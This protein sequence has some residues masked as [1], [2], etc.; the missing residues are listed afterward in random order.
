M[1]RKNEFDEI[2]QKLENNDVLDNS[3]GEEDE[4]G[5]ILSEVNKK[6]NCDSEDNYDEIGD[7]LSEVNK[8]RNCDSEDNS[9]DEIGDILSEVNKK[10]K[11]DSEENTVAKKS[12][13]NKEDEEEYMNKLID[14][15]AK[16]KKPKQKRRKNKRADKKAL[17]QK[18]A[19]TMANNM[20]IDEN[21]APIVSKIPKS[22]ESEENYFKF[23]PYIQV[24]EYIVKENSKSDKIAE[25]KETIRTR[26]DLTN[27]FNTLCDKPIFIFEDNS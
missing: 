25:S 15:C 1:G 16:K 10:R 27:Y 7:I 12:K 21:I 26:E 24:R 19:K 3:D 20:I 4:I 9:D 11:R 13:S 8:K 23:D 17:K 18:I 6:R 2:L 14:E 5:D 22:Y